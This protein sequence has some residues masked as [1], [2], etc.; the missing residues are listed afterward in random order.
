M[1]RGQLKAFVIENVNLHAPS[2]REEAK[3]LMPLAK[4]AKVHVSTLYV[5]DQTVRKVLRAANGSSVPAPD[6]DHA[7]NGNGN[8]HSANAP[9]AAV[10]VLTSQ[11]YLRHLAEC[12]EM[13][14]TLAGQVHATAEML[15]ALET[16]EI[17][18]ASRLA[19]MAAEWLDT[20][21]APVD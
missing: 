17:R 12:R 1:E 9:T 7:G 14:S 21:T 2:I 16:E 15:A 19:Q 11:A 4:R 6:P 10:P 3:R 20:R 8:G 13:L 18:R 5:M